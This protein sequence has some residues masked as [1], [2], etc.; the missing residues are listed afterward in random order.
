M[1][2]NWRHRRGAFGRFRAA[3]IAE[4][5]G[6]RNLVLGFCAGSE[7]G[8]TGRRQR[9]SHAWQPR[10]LCRNPKAVAELIEQAARGSE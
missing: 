9:C 4:V 6:S 3:P 2:V 8:K 7:T 5:R 1:L 10:H